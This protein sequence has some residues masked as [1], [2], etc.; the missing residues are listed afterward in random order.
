MFAHTI[1]VELAS[2]P[3]LLL[4]LDEPTSGL[5]SQ[6]SWAILDLLDKLKKND[7]AILC[8]THQPS[9]MLFQRFDRLLILK[10]DGQSVYYG[11]VGESSHILIDYF[12]RNGGP[13]CPLAANPAEWILEVI[14]AA[15]GS[16][17][18]IDWFDIWRKSSE[19]P[20]VQEHLA[21]LKLERSQNANLS[22]TV[23]S[24]KQDKAGYREFAA[25]FSNQLF[26]VQ[27]RVFQQIWRTPTY[28]YSKTFQCVSTSLYIGFSLYNT[29]NTLQGLQNQMLS[30]FVLFFLFRQLIQQIM[31]HS[32]TQRALYEAQD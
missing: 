15:P 18:D 6:T 19:Y 16:H 26:E 17:T 20:R 31:P 11:D 5:D 30:V 4:F 1:G 14:G 28:I 24:Q 25:P 27:L 2:R 23:S 8:T 29:P 9:A 10:S 22:R 12:T 7:Q 3:A 13:P 32:V 21:E